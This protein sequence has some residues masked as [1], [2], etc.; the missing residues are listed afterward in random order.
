MRP[1]HIKAEVICVLSP[2]YIKA[3]NRIC[4]FTLPLLRLVPADTV[5][6]CTIWHSITRGETTLTSYRPSEFHLQ[7]LLSYKFWVEHRLFWFVAPCVLDVYDVSGFL[8][9]SIITTTIALWNVG[10]HQK[11]AIFILAAVKMSN[12]TSRNFFTKIFTQK[13]QKFTQLSLRFRDILGSNPGKNPAINT[14]F[15]YS[16]LQSTR[17]NVGIIH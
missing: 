17:E 12:P 9:A 3:I 2:K 7:V 16:F 4:S 5:H 1:L 14:A 15:L 6:D 11:T 13:L 8:A 10:K